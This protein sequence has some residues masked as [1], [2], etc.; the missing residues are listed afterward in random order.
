MPVEPDGS[1]YFEVPA[2]R[3]L[4]FVA[5]DENDRSVKRMQSFTTVAPGETLGCV[6][7]HEHR[8]VTPPASVA[9]LPQ[10]TGRPASRIKPLQ[11]VPDLVDFPRDIQPILDR[12]CV[13]CHNP[14]K[15]DG[16]VLLT[17]DRGP[18]FSHAYYSLVVWRQVAD[19]RNEPRSNYTP[20]TLGSGGSPLVEKLEP[21]HYG[22][23]VS[24]EER[25]TVT[26]WLDLGAPYPGTYAALG[27]GMIGGYQRNLQ[28]LEN[29]LQWPETIAAQ[30]AFA[31]RCATCHND[32]DVS[33][34]R[35]LSDETKL[36]FWA[37]KMDDPRLRR[38]RHV[39]FNLTRP[40]KSL[41]LLAP[42]ARSAGGYGLCRAAQTEAGT[43]TVF[44]NVGDPDYHALRAM[45]EAGQRRLNEIKRFDMPGFRPRPEYVREMKRY[46]VLPA[47]YD[48]ATDP[49]DVYAID[50]SYWNLF[51]WEP[52]RPLE[53]ATP[54][55]SRSSV[56]PI[57]RGE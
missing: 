14:D 25:R 1:A 7:C 50:R 46:G 19:G 18:M 17:G 40:E 27:T 9:R 49:I 34:P 13:S 16:G 2:T 11:G 52:G 47:S 35:S 42:L 41:Y 26:L 28:V 23:K 56:S 8:V 45:C 33:L 24:P 55:V 5:L 20:R 4:F 57:P 37:P 30:T 6:G 10:A 15:R 12:H 43:G 22:V 44:T 51:V 36:S 32:K 3:S 31:R 29:D 38:S 48:L 21:T 53:A 39:V 54:G